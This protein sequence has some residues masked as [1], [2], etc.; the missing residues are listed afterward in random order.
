LY[1]NPGDES[2]TVA[3]KTTL[4][5][6]KRQSVTNQVYE[7]LKAQVLRRAWL[8]G[9]KLPS[10]NLLAQQLGV[11][12]VSVREG[13]QRLV[14]L[15]LL[16]TRHGEGTFVCEYGA[17]ASMNA[18]IPMLALDPA[19]LFHVLEYRRIMEKGT[20]AL[21]AE[22]ATDEDVAELKRSYAA[23]IEQQF[24]VSGF[25]HADLEFHLALARASGN[26]I[27]IKV[28]GIIR[29]ILSVSMESIV[30]SLGTQDGLDYHQRIIEAIE[31][32]DAR[33]AESIMEEHV[34]RTIERL[35]TEGQRPSPELAPG[36]P[37]AENP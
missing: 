15:G 22:K 28:N 25:A 16:E 12:R 7:Q 5:R 24:D 36:I 8:P 30:Q 19:D 27:I 21:V 31:A 34:L 1:Y 18:L 17:G 10:E 11:S 4:R 6:V 14:S 37:G 32:H 26:P 23:M 13:L 20:V 35:R 9:S 33:R 29:D 3:N 2:R